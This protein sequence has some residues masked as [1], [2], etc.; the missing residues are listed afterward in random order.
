VKKLSTES[1]KNVRVVKKVSAVDF[2]Q[3]IDPGTLIMALQ[4]DLVRVHDFAMSQER[5]TTYVLSDFN[6]Q[7][8]AVVTQ[9]K[10]KTMIVLPSKIGELDP[11][12][13]SLVNITLKPIP[14]PVKPTTEIRPVEAIEGIGLAIGERLRTR[15]IQTVSDLAQASSQTLIELNIPRKKAEEF[16]SMSKLML[17]GN[18]AG[19]EGVDEQAA[20]M[21]VVAGKI[22]SKE[23]LAQAN[24]EQLLRVINEAIEAKKVK[25]PAKRALAVED[26][27]R[28]V[29]SAKAIVERN[30]SEA[31][32]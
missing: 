19:V 20:E 31:C 23:K 1:N 13:L 30:S 22:D 14:L 21:L 15:G 6:I 25:I 4:K 7:L 2:S 27:K 28:W 29:N 18:I 11:N 9:E 8:K 10:D 32:E 24:P 17:K 26:V 12:L 3:K 5:P 16:I